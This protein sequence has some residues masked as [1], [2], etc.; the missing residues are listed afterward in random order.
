MYKY[1]TYSYRTRAIWCRRR[2]LLLLLLEYCCRE[3]R[4]RRCRSQTGVWWFVFIL[5]VFWV[6]V[7]SPSYTVPERVYGC[8]G[9]CKAGFVERTG[10]SHVVIS[11]PGW[12]SRVALCWHEQCVFRSMRVVCPSVC[13]RTH[14]RQYWIRFNENQ[15]EF[16]DVI[17]HGSKSGMVE[18]RTINS[19]F[20]TKH[21]VIL[22]DNSTENCSQLEL[23]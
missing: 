12:R 8:G 13:V 21:L 20:S 17:Q 10:W 22:H 4:Q 16:N 2:R 7:F 19:L 11:R 1:S 9:N 6:G 5:Y 14:V 23:A 18:Q 3:C 15:T